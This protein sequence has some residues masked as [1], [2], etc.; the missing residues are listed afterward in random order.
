M[1][2]VIVWS[3]YATPLA[4]IIPQRSFRSMKIPK[5]FS[6]HMSKSA[7]VSRIQRA[8]SKGASTERSTA[9]ADKFAMQGLHNHRSEVLGG[10]D[11]QE[12]EDAEEVD[13]LP[14]AQGRTSLKTQKK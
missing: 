12:L 8:S 10:A 11:V 1:Q 4:V 5:V 14:R 7:P 3:G 9:G 6:G 2:V 13:G